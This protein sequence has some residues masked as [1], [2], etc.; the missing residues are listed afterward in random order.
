MIL[1]F[2]LILHYLKLVEGETICNIFLPE[3]ILI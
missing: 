1:N 3:Y 2:R